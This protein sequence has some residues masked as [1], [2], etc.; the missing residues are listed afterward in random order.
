MADQTP[1][2][3]T[4]S[5][6]PYANDQR[7]IVLRR[8]NAVV[9][10]DAQSRQLQVRNASKQAVEPTECPTCRRPY[11]DEAIHDD[12]DYPSPAFGHERQY[13]DPEYFAMLAASHRGTPEASGSNTPSRRFFP[14]ALRSGRSRDVSGSADPPAG[15][16]FLG[17]APSATSG[18][19]ISSSAFSPDFFKRNFVE[20]GVLGRGGHGVVLL[21]EHF[22]DGVS[23][24]Q[25]ACKRVPVGNDRAWLEKVLVEVKLLQRIQHRNLVQYHFVWLEDHQ[26][27]R[28]GPSIPCL[29]ILQEYCDGGDLQSYVHG[30]KDAPTTAET[31]KARLRRRSRGDSDTTGEVRVPSKLTFEEIFSFFRDITAGLHHLHSK[32]YIH[33]DLKPSNCLLQ[34]DG[35]KTRV[36]I[37]DFGEV[38][39]AGDE[40]RSTG[41]TGTIS[42]C[43]P[44]V[45]RRDSPDGIFGNFTTKSDIFSLGMCVYFMCFARLPYSNADD[46]NEEAEDLDQLRVEITSWPG[47]DDKARARSD[48][49][50]KLYRFLKRLL[51][52]DPDERPSTGDILE[53]IRGGNVNEAVGED[54]SPRVSSV[55]SPAR[56]TPQSRKHST[57]HIR[58]GLSSLGRRDSSDEDLRPRSPAKRDSSRSEGHSRPLSPINGAVAVR[59]SK[60]ELPKPGELERPHSPR[61]LLPAP[62][63]A[64]G[65]ARFPM[66]AK[67]LNAVDIARIGLLVAKVL[68]LTVP[69]APYAANSWLLYPLLALAALDFGIF[70]HDLRRSMMLL[71]VHLA[72]LVIASQRGGLCERPTVRWDTV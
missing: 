35:T 64:S 49:P 62:P 45:L 11:R 4:M 69:C 1:P 22:M 25:Y 36:L 55:D 7:E 17:S 13:V 56:P 38:Q 57:Y 61:L 26:P 68:T 67:H 2:R 40:R 29:W 60:V 3:Q 54:F 18:Q 6:I 53:S 50:E 44:E 31:L 8:G 59:P 9:V 42:Y 5:L 12:E 63:I 19:G 23:L 33:R 72:G 48:L 20:Q 46:I 51:S 24:G 71:G 66:L 47:F 15:S 16:E 27:N 52:V 65:P 41:A 10:Y 70:S 58:P 28:F 21:V 32:G 34:R 14:A 39:A 37:S 30:P 43:A